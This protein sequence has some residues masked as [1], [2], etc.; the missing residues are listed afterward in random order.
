[1][2]YIFNVMAVSETWASP[3]SIS[4]GIGVV[5]GVGAFLALLHFQVTPVTESNT[6]RVSL[7]VG[8]LVLAA[9]VIAWKPES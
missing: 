7:L 9:L 2:A 1:M 4:Y 8:A 3:T 6:V 5:A